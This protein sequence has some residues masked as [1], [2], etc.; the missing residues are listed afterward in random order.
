MRYETEQAILDEA[1]LVHAVTGETLSG[2]ANGSNKVFTTTYKRICDA[3]DDDE[4][5]SNDV[6]VYVNGT[7]VT[8]SS[9][10]AAEGSITLLAAPANGAA[11][12]CDYFYTN[13]SSDYVCKAREEAEDWVNLEMT[14]VD[15]IPYTNEV[16]ATIRKI[17]R[18]YAAG[19]LLLKDY[20]DRS[21]TEEQAKNG[22]QK[23]KKAEKWMA[24]YVLLGGSTGLTTTDESVEVESDPALFTTYDRQEGKYRYASDDEF[25]R[26]QRSE[27]N[28]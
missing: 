11:I 28:L 15:P 7:R 21:D 5:D 18:Y 8:V 26:G 2:T 12:T 4:V 20:G 22:D 16:P 24:R 3:N 19:L 17:T 1:G 9:V 13:V 14:G 25:M 23:I 10:D 6:T 27:E